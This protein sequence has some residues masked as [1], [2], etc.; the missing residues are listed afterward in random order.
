M[1]GCERMS[2]VD[3]VCNGGENVEDRLFACWSP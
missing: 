1:G 3:G 2:D